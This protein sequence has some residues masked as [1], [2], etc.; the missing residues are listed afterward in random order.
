M[1][2]EDSIKSRESLNRPLLFEIKHQQ[3]G[4]NFGHHIRDEQN[5]SRF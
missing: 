3:L 2:S 4:D 1:E 5:L